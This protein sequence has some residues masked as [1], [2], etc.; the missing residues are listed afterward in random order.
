MNFHL[1]V[2][3]ELNNCDKANQAT[4]CENF[5]NL[6]INEM[7]LLINDEKRHLLCYW[8]DLNSSQSTFHM[9]WQ[10]LELYALI[11]LK[12]VEEKTASSWDDLNVV[13]FQHNRDINKLKATIQEEISAIPNNMMQAV[14]WSCSR[15]WQVMDV[16]WQIRHLKNEW[17]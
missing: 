9:L 5:L 8:S 13:W 10:V 17:Y 16:I 4:F 12:R 1:V 15:G 14:M 3:Q 6:H 11:S 7:V 2:L